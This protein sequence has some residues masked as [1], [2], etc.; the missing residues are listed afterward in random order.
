MSSSNNDEENEKDL[1][2]L[3]QSSLDIGGG[4]NVTTI[5]W[6]KPFST[7]KLR[8]VTEEDLEKV[9][10]EPQFEEFYDIPSVGTPAVIDL[11]DGN[12]PTELFLS[13]DE[14][15]EVSSIFDD[16]IYKF[17]TYAKIFGTGV[18]GLLSTADIFAETFTP[19]G[20]ATFA[21]ALDGSFIMMLSPKEQEQEQP[22]QR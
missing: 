2:Q 6:D 14:H 8:E 5:P 9:V 3:L 18:S 21:V 13:Y 17:K 15:Y 4:G 19:D 1:I 16:Y 22:E 11:V 7:H 12:I 10:L 20:E